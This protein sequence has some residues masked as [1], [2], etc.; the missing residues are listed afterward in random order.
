MV[1]VITFTSSHLAMSANKILR[2]Q[3]YKCEVIPT[4][5]EIS[6]EC[7]FAL[8]IQV[9]NEETLNLYFKEKKIVYDKIYLK[10]GD[11]YEDCRW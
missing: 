2:K 11:F 4:P 9:E 7:G 8:L 3:E 10:R 5:R 1:F 6:S